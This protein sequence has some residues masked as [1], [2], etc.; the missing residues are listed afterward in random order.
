M[1]NYSLNNV[2]RFDFFID[3]NEYWDMHLNN[4]CLGSYSFSGIELNEPCLASYIDTDIEGCVS[5]N[6]LNSSVAYSEACSFGLNLKNIGFTGVDNG[7]I[8]Y[9]KDRITNEE[10]YKLY[11]ESEYNISA[12]DLTLHLHMVSGN[13]LQYEYPVSIN[14]DGTI[15]LNGGF[16]Q[17]FFRSDKTYNILPSNIDNVWNFEFIL[18]KENYAKESNKTLNDKY[19][20]NKGIFFYIGTRAQNKWIY[21]YDNLVDE[22]DTFKCERRE[23]EFD[24]VEDDIY[25]ST[26]E[27]K[28]DNVFDLNSSND[29]YTMSDNKF[30]MYDRTESGL[31]A[32][33]TEG[34]EE[35]IL[36]YKKYQSKENLFL[37]LNRTPTGYT[38]NDSDEITSGTTDAYNHLDFYGDIFENA[39]SFFINDEGAI[40]YK[41]AIKDCENGDEHHLKIESGQSYDNM[42]NIGEWTKINVKIK[43]SENWMKIYF[44]VN[45]KLKYIT[46]QLPKLNLHS[47]NELEEKQ[48]GVAYN[49]SIGGGT[50]GLMETIMPNYM[51][52]PTDEFDLE[53]H[54]AGTFIGDFKSFKFYTC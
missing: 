7:L 47:L 19:P 40:G 36:I 46:K 51:F 43:V 8:S 3:E 52:N 28:T 26:K 42:I 22:D 39:L 5:G 34:D 2:R 17:G 48:E 14:E 31:T 15:K 41:Y 49:I 12:D 21:L 35:A 32:S 20:D 24:L 23:D 4:D 45:N 9:K 1:S 13:T 54:F 10:F 25:L 18:K 37:Y 11:T 16:Y 38:A 30:L 50:Q 44:Y 53:K 6:T 29:A 27:F 33:N